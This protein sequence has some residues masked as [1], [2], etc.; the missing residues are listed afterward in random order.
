MVLLLVDDVAIAGSLIKH[1]WTGLKIPYHNALPSRQ[2]LGGVSDLTNKGQFDKLL[3][4]EF[5]NDDLV[6]LSRVANNEALYYNREMPPVP[7][8]VERVVLVDVSLKCWGTPKIIEFAAFLAIVRHPKTD[9]PCTAFAIGNN[10]QPLLFENIHQV[11]D[12]LQL[13]ESGLHCAEGLQLFLKEYTRLHK[14]EVFLIT[15]PE[16]LK[17]PAMQKAISDNNTYFKYI[18]TAGADGAMHLY[19]N[20]HNARK[21]IQDIKLPL[22]ELWKRETVQPIKNRRA[23]A[24]I[25]YPILFNNSVVYKKVMKTDDEEVFMVTANRSVLKLYDKNKKYNEKGWQ[26]IWENLPNACN[27]FALGVVNRQHVLLCFNDQTKNIQLINLTTRKEKHILFSKWERSSYPNFIFKG[28]N[29]LYHTSYNHTVIQYENAS[30]TTV[31]SHGLAEI[32]DYEDHE[33]RNLA[34]NRGLPQGPSILLNINTVFINQVD[35]LV[36]NIHELLM[37]NEGVIKLEKTGFDNQRIMATRSQEGDVFT[38]ADGSFITIN[39]SGML[40]LESSNEDIPVIYIPPVLNK[41]LGAAT[42]RQFAGNQYY[43]PIRDISK[44]VST[45]KFWRDNIEE[46][47]KN[48]KLKC[49]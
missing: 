43:N 37:N 31:P 26:L 11:I 3:I 2:P 47:I 20:K 17:M 19:Q 13:L 45:G 38:F 34:I 7:D 40:V 29:F 39:F 27:Y 18:I 32:Q 4:S 23:V 14:I 46:F 12:G 22:T 15:S 9:I 21:L 49:S 10:Y 8:N 41:S 42:A 33:K 24:P 25:Y 30:I 36:F 48:I 5:A 1:I 28:G 44:T 16:S 6:F 35:N